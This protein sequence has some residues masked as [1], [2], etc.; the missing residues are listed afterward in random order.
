VFDAR[1]DDGFALVDC[2]IVNAVR[3]VPPAN[4]P[5]PAEIGTCRRFLVGEI[6]GAP[7]P[8]VLLA[9]G[10]IA[11]ESV[12][13]AVGVP[14]RRHPFGHGAAQALPSGQ[15]LLSSFH[16]SRYNVNTGVLTPAMF[17]AVVAQ[18]ALLLGR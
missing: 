4:K 12:L 2:R 8:R 14:L 16:T 9:L 7:P 13:R 15:T 5:T 17:D 1:V 3:C 6:A 11:H 18:A 10:R